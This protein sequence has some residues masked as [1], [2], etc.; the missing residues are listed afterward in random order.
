MPE[1]FVV[2]GDIECGL[3][4]DTVDSFC[5]EDGRVFAAKEN[6]NDGCDGCA[7]KDGDGC[8]ES[9]PCSESHRTDEKSII[10]VEVKPP[11]KEP[12]PKKFYMV[13]R[14][15]VDTLTW[16]AHNMLYRSVEEADATMEQMNLQYRVVEVVHTM[17]PTFEYTKS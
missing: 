8:V 1:E 10:W 3:V 9:P 17:T 13:L 12:E 15:N 7:F 2:I 4:G 14:W 6:G 16:N 5:T 11:T